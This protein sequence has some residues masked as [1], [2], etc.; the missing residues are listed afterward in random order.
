MEHG[1]Q[2]Y[3][4]HPLSFFEDASLGAGG[5]GE[6][7]LLAFVLMGLGEGASLSYKDILFAH[8]KG[9]KTLSSKHVDWFVLAL[10]PTPTPSAVWG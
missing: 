3:L 1:R 8:W 7:L 2:Q 6:V 5:G 10:G 9:K 4:F